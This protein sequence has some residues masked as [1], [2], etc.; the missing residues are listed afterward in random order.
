MSGCRSTDTPYT[1]K[2]G[3]SIMVFQKSLFWP[4]IPLYVLCTSYFFQIVFSHHH[5]SWHS[6]PGNT[7][8]SIKRKMAL[9]RRLS[10]QVLIGSTGERAHCMP[11]PPP[12]P[13]STAS[14]SKSARVFIYCIFKILLCSL[15]LLCDF[16]TKHISFVCVGVSNTPTHT[17]THYSQDLSW[18]RLLLCLFVC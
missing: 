5:F 7:P 8:V 16:Q 10:N 18:R 1:R 9:I 11:P 17:H 13:D 6:F 14:A 2:A 3:V 15:Q 4:E 12:A